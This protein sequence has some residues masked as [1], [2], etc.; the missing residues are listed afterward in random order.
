[1]LKA[2]FWIAVFFFFISVLFYGIRFIFMTLMNFA[3]SSKPKQ[4]TKL[5]GKNGSTP[6]NMKS[7]K[8]DHEIQFFD[9]TLNKITTL[10]GHLVKCYEEHQQLWIQLISLGQSAP[11]TIK[12]NN[13]SMVENLLTKE[14]LS[15]ENSIEQYFKRFL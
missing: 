7:L 10:S 12:V 13:I 14:R 5:I 3:N 8:S 6:S 4:S 2:I 11:K 1:M 9:P 15:N